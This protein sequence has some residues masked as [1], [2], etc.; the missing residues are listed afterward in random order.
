[1][2]YNSLV[3]L[4]IPLLIEAPD[5][6]AADALARDRVSARS[7][8]ANHITA[9]SSEPLSL[10]EQLHADNLR[11]MQELHAVET[12]GTA[13]QLARW[14]G[15]CLPERELCD[16][17]RDELFKP[18]ADLPLRRKM[19]RF[20]IHGVAASCP[21]PD[22]VQWSVSSRPTLLP[23]QWERLEQI[24]AAAD[25]AAQH[26]WL[27]LSAPADVVQISVRS[28][29]GVCGR[30][31]RVKVQQSALVTITWAGR[32]LSREYAL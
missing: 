16:I 25:T 17:A 7:V 4:S 8:S 22:S 29:S 10:V 6:A 14:F 23:E 2:L 9:V 13:S 18:F 26:Q 3:S 20:D 12:R 15:G 32:T 11:T 30:C 27:R 24:R 21:L 31:A 28:H 1:M 5:A 19:T